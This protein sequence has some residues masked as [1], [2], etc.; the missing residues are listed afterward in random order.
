MNYPI[1]EKLYELFPDE[2]I[3]KI[4]IK[5]EILRNK[6]NKNFK[7]KFPVISSLGIKNTLKNNIYVNL[8]SSK[9][10]KPNKEDN[11][12]ENNNQT[13]LNEYDIDILKMKRQII[14]SPIAS[15]QL[16]KINYFGP[17]YSYCPSCGIKNLHFYQKLPLNRLIKLTNII[18]K[19]KIKK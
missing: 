16:E 12:D 10:S 17:Y 18:K 2:E 9:E 11:K 15:R 6:T 3:D 1:K 13:Y 19:Y 5:N 14:K 4:Q 7:E 8:L